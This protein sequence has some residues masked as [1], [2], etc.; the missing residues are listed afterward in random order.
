MWMINRAMRAMT[1]VAILFLAPTL[2]HAEVHPIGSW[3]VWGA[4]RDAAVPR[5][6][7]VSEPMGRG[8]DSK[9]YMSVGYWPGRKV[10]AQVHVR[11]SRAKRP[12]SAI[13]LRV[14]GLPYQ[15]VG[16]GIAAW[17]P[18]PRADAEIVAAMRTG[19][20]MVVETRSERGAL[21]RDRYALRGAASA[22]DA[23][24]IACAKQ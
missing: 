8:S 21:I 7:A 17:G 16:S 1:G 6:W 13:L 24:G 23:A 11:L 18:D 19:V 3:G 5:C 4:F 22:I 9:P 10:R 14:D 12:G 15:L 2:A 20:E